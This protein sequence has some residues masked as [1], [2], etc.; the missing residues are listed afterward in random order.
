MRRQGTFISRYSAALRTRLG[1]IIC[2]QMTSFCRDVENTRRA[3]TLKA[4]RTLLVFPALFLGFDLFLF[5]IKVLER[6]IH[7]KDG[8]NP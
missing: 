1:S 4:A 3:L 6:S 5:C 8:G 2:H 7:N